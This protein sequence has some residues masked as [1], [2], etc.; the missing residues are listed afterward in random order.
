MRKSHQVEVANVTRG[1]VLGSEIRIADTGLTRL[2]GLL[3]NSELRPGCGLLIEPSSGVHTFGMRFPIDVVAL[4]RH[5]CVR[6][7]WESL[8]PFRIAALGF[9]TH[10]VLELPVGSIRHSRTQVNDQL[11]LLEPGT[12]GAGLH[13]ADGTRSAPESADKINQTARSIKGEQS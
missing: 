3:G 4:D 5:L 2:V 12:I 8:G 7:V 10:K 1:T 6:G 11:V 9:K 13:H